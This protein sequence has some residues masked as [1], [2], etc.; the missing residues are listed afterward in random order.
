MTSEAKPFI[1]KLPPG[2]PR[3]KMPPALSRVRD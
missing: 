1:Y 2:T 3:A